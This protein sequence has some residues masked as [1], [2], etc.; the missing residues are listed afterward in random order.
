MNFVITSVSAPT[1]ANAE[2]TLIH[3]MIETDVYGVIPF[4][5]SPDDPESHGRTIFQAAVNG[6][7]GAIAEYVPPP[8]TEADYTRAVQAKLDAEAA[9]HGYDSILSAC[10][11]A[12]VANPFQADGVAFLNWRSAVW[13]TCY[14]VLTA[15][16]AGQRSQPTVADLIGE[17]P[18]LVME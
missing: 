7:F 16:Q 14:Q 2:H 11:Y 8:I 13:A 4:A 12:A 5:A 15:V 6:E 17:L 3:C 1:W 18:P 10:S 9:A